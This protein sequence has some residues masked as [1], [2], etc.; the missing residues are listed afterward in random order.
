MKKEHQAILD[1]LADGKRRS[2][3]EIASWIGISIPETRD[4]CI[5]LLALGVVKSNTKVAEM[6]NRGENRA[7]Q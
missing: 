4:L 1:Y 7:L 2:V 3:C 5:E 6:N